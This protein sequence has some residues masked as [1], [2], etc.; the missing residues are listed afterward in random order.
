MPATILRHRVN[1]EAGV[2]EISQG[3][4]SFWP[5][6]I[7]EGISIHDGNEDNFIH[8][9]PEEALNRRQSSN[10]NL[11]STRAIHISIRKRDYSAKRASTAPKRSDSSLQHPDRQLTPSFSAYTNAS[12]A[13]IPCR[14]KYS[15]KP[16]TYPSDSL[17]CP[18]KSGLGPSSPCSEHCRTHF[19]NPISECSGSHA[20]M[21]NMPTVG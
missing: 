14:M 8:V 5:P 15:K 3:T 6:E 21:G 9:S 7:P 20:S 4:P 16:L 19:T 1:Q 10:T 2:R 13:C 12:M 18:F 11:F 17:F